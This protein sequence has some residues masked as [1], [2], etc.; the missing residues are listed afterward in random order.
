VI[1]AT[2]ILG[3]C[4]AVVGASGASAIEPAKHTVAW[5]RTHQQAR[6][7]VL[8]TCQNDHSFDD[9]GDCRNAQSASHGALADSLAT[10]TGKA[11][12]EA[13]PAY[14]GRDGGMIALTLASCAHHEAPASWCKAAQIASANL[15]R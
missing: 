7:S 1:R 5:Y 11:E 4:L 10:N 3:V 13:D 2:V 9:S 14:Y 12:P 6:E 8:A 15:H